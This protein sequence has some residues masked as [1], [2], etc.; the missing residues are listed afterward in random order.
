MKSNLLLIFTI[1]ILILSGKSYSQMD[2]LNLTAD[3][4]YIKDLEPNEL[5]NGKGFLITADSGRSYIVI[6]ASIR[7]NGAYDINGLQSEQT[8][9]TYEIPVGSENTNDGRFFI[10]PYQT[11]FG[12]EAQKLTSLGNIFIKLET[13][14]L[15]NNNNLR[16]RQAYGVIKSF[17]LGKARSVFSD[18]DAIPNKVDRDGPNSSLNQRTVQI[19][20][21]P[22]KK[23]LLRWAVSLETPDP[24]IT[25]PDS[26]VLEPVFQSFPDIASNFNVSSDSW[27]HVQLASVFRGI[28]VRDP[29]GSIQIIPGYGGLF[30]GKLKILKKTNLMYQLY[31]GKGMARYVKSLTGQGLDVV[32]DYEDN[33]FKALNTYGGYIAT[34]IKWNKIFSN[35]LTVGI[36]RIVNIDSQPGDAFK[37]SYY[38]S[39]NL[40]MYFAKT[41][42][43]GIEYS[44]GKRINKNDQSGD[45]NRI[46]FISILDF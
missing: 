44:Y 33:T 28:S 13:D 1:L 45:A 21:Q 29:G 43:I 26:L 25:E 39:G 30:S 17:L 40:F 12:L 32:Y 37:V 15:G 31:G 14:F 46:S 8:F 38:A 35:D 20:F 2:S 5:P 42:N 23:D 19:R 6:K 9:D 18:A 4:V 27:G 24:D 41:L 11:R 10:S 7:L 34:G 22:P 3:S 16:I 36:T